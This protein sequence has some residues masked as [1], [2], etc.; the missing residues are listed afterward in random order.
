MQLAVIQNRIGISRVLVRSR[1]GDHL[2]QSLG[3]W[4]QTILSGKKKKGPAISSG[5]V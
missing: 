5:R 4:M 2:L 3:N 1:E